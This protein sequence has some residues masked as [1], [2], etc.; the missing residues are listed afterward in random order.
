[1]RNDNVL[2][3]RKL[4]PLGT[5]SAL[6]PQQHMAA[7]FSQESCWTPTH[8]VPGDSVPSWTSSVNGWPGVTNMMHVRSVHS[9]VPSDFSNKHQRKD[10]EDVG[11]ERCS[12][13]DLRSRPSSE[14]DSA[15]ADST[16][17]G[18]PQGWGHHS[19]WHREADH[20]TLG[21]TAGEGRAESNPLW[22]NLE[23]ICFA[24]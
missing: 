9:I 24:P 21:H 23:S 3:P 15:C 6:A 19:H 17:S 7:L 20:L 5:V 1:M 2:V 10:P 12:G 11:T 22:S 14:P 16:V 4:W 13:R 18:S 8:W